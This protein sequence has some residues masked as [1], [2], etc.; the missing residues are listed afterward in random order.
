ML[1]GM[2]NKRMLDRTARLLELCEF[3]CPEPGGITI[4]PK[5]HSLG[6]RDMLDMIAALDERAMA[7]L[8]YLAFD[9]SQVEEFTGPWGVHFAL[10]INL[11]KRLNCRVLATSLHGQPAKVARLFR[12]SEDIRALC[13]SLDDDGAPQVAALAFRGD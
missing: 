9:F 4:Q 1:R 2:L 8:K 11:S 7:N 6:L 3:A 5:V 10:L 13:F 12:Q